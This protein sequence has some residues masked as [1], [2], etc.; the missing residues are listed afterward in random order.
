MLNLKMNNKHNYI[1]NS[2]K[3][4]VGAVGDASLLIINQ[5][6]NKKKSINEWRK[7]KKLY[8]ISGKDYANNDVTSKDINYHIIS[9]FIRNNGYFDDH[10]FNLPL[11]KSYFLDTS[12][13]IK[14]NW[15]QYDDS[16]PEGLAVVDGN[17]KEIYGENYPISPKIIREGH[18]YTTLQPQLLTRIT[19]SRQKLID[20]SNDALNDY[21]FF[22]LRS[23]ISDTI[24]L[25]E[26]TLTQI[27]IK[28]EYKPLPHWK[29]EIEKLGVRHGRRFED[30]LNWIYQI[31]GNHLN[32]EK[33]IPSFNNLRE[34]RNHMMHFDPPS[35]IITIEEATMWLNQIIDVGWL[36][37]KMRQAVG[38]EISMPLV[39]FILQKEAVFNPQPLFSNRLPIGIGNTD[40]MSS[41][42]PKKK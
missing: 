20:T 38:T 33:Y 32:A 26:I 15:H 41:T 16:A 1:V 4:R 29:F 21:W 3:P 30:K 36:L 7:D 11:I 13:E 40:Y 28:A 9:N 23:L 27:Y 18:T 8:K 42:W 25:V 12:V 10:E 34:L 14:I 22:D 5:F 24:S 2:D 31:S 19:Q 6:F 39:N 35:L 37:I 17:N